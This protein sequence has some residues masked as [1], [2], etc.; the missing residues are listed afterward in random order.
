MSKPL[1]DMSLRAARRN[2]AFR[3]GPVLFLH[4]RAFAD[5]LERIALVRR[6]FSDALLIGCPDPAWPERL[7]A[8][9]GR[10]AVVDPGP[11]FAVAAGGRRLD[12][13]EERLE[14]QFDLC[15]AVGT[16]DTVNQLPLALANIRAA[17]G[18]D[19][20]LIGAVSGGNTLPRL[21]G[22]MRDADT[23]MSGAS[24]RV[25]PRID[26]PSLGGLLTE[27]GFVMPVVDVD[28]VSV[29]YASLRKLV[30]DLRRMAATNILNDRSHLPLSRRALAAAEKS[31][32][33]D[34]EGRRT[35]ETFEILHFAA[36]TPGDR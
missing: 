36:W 35:T 8:L 7:A 19:A 18:P 29:R 23:L 3:Q 9:A 16:L 25:H 4:E 33:P 26:G 22:A 30:G 12:E 10:V 15:V 2:R 11:A 21:R 28:K 14:G 1:F 17:L 5:I 32:N 6:R 27:V 34:E 31:F 13:D 24:P 20:L